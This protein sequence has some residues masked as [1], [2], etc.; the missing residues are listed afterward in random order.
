MKQ[1]K[2]VFS[3]KVVQT[4]PACGKAPSIVLCKTSYCLISRPMPP[5]RRQPVQSQGFANISNFSI[6]DL[7]LNNDK[8]FFLPEDLLK[9]D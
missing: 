9:S 3:S 1:L 5:S 2:C 6:L 7:M 4:S 8:L